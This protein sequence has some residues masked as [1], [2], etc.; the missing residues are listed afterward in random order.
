MGERTVR[1]GLEAGCSALTWHT[2]DGKHLWGRNY[3]FDRLA[4]GSGVFFFPRGTAYRTAAGPAG[5][6]AVAAGAGEDSTGAAS[7]GAVSVGAG[8]SGAACVGAGSAVTAA[9]SATGVSTAAA[10]GAAAESV[11]GAATAAG[12]NFS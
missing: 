2:G 1:T 3:D 4:E 7:A 12:V 8:S 5:A 10:S 11:S 6:G 9:A